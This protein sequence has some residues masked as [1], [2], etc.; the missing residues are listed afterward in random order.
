AVDVER[1]LTVAAGLRALLRQ[2]PEV[3][4]VGE[5][6][7]PETAQVALNA[8]LTGHRL[9]SSLHALNASE[10]L[11]RLLDMGAA[12]FMLSSALGGVLSQRLVRKLCPTCARQS[13]RA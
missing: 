1:G 5:I 12:P 7:D 11:V 13:E 8:A 10:A 6:R 9:L 2:D 3:L 4:M